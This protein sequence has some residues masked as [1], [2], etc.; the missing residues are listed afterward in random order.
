MHSADTPCKSLA[1]PAHLFPR[2]QNGVQSA[3]PKIITAGFK[4]VQLIYYFTAGQVEVS[5][6]TR[7]V[8]VVSLFS[9]HK[10]A[11]F[12]WEG[13]YVAAAGVLGDCTSIS[14]KAV[15]SLPV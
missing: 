10:R 12:C 11:K 5:A 6:L 1:S 15:L 4:A 2:L 8:F 14:R 3:L 7:A 9:L 13:S